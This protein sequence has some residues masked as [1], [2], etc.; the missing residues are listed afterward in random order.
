[1]KKSNQ[2]Y[3]AV[4]GLE[5]HAELK[6]Q[7]KMFCS[8]ANS[9]TRIMPNENTNRRESKPTEQNMNICPVCLG[10]PGML[11]V[12]NKQAIEMTIKTGLY[13]NNKKADNIATFTKWDRKNY[14]YPD[15]P[16]GY[17]ISQYDLP[18]VTGGLLKLKTENEKLITFGITRIHLEED[19]GTSKHPEGRADVDY[20]LMDYNRAGVPLMELVTDAVTLPIDEAGRIAKLFCQSYQLR[21]RKLD[22]S[23]ADMEKGQMRCEANISVKPI[24]QKEFGTKVEVKNLNSFK[25]VEKAIEFELERQI[26]EIENGGKIVQETRGWDEVKNKTYIMR[27]KETSADYRYFPEPDLPP[28]VIGGNSKHETLNSKQ[29][30]NPKFKTKNI[31]NINEI[32]KQLPETVEEVLDRY[33]NKFGLNKIDANLII[34]DSERSKLFDKCANLI[35][36]DSKVELAVWIINDIKD[37][38]IN[39]AWFVELICTIKVGKISKSVAKE[40]LSEL[41]KGKKPSEIIKERGL[42]QISDIGELEKIVEKVISKNPDVVAKIKG[43]Q[44]QIV[45]FLVGCVMKESKGQANPQV[46]NEIL[47]NKLKV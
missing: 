1:M 11:P 26:D 18:I 42:E 7:S 31:I 43:G 17:Q 9:T 34:S 38:S 25:S 4:I 12:L 44:T 16:K 23:D 21:L 28:V 10:M 30:Q 24:G 6:T 39:P 20:S 45:G 22:V 19:T 41:Y 46:V 33:Q 5:I 14:F 3:E 29:I 2:K 15:L 32:I 36:D 13:L 37:F 35:S 40:I 8:C 47:N 27:V